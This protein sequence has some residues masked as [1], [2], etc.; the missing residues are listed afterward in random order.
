MSTH[1]IGPKTV[2]YELVTPGCFSVYTNIRYDV[3]TIDK[4]DQR[5]TRFACCKGLQ[6]FSDVGA[7]E[8]H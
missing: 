1:G 8:I 7:P 3:R 2:V 6:R 4:N 5:E